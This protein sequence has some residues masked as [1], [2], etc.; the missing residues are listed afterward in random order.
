MN[1]KSDQIYDAFICHATEDKEAVARPLAQALINTGLRIWYDEFSLKL[2]DSLRQSIERGLVQSRFGIV[3]ISPQF[4]E[5]SWPQAELNGL[6][7][8]EMTGDKVII[9]VWFKVEYSD[10]VKRSP[11]MADKVA[12]KIADGMDRVVEQILDVIEMPDKY[13]WKVIEFHDGILTVELSSWKCFSDYV[14]KEISGLYRYIF[15]GQREVS[16]ELQPTLFRAIYNA[17][18]KKYYGLAA[19]SLNFK[20][21]HAMRGRRGSNPKT[22]S[23]NE[24]WA[25]GQQFGLK[26]VLLDWTESPFLASF[27]AFHEQ[28][29]KDRNTDKRIVYAISRFDIRDK[30]DE[31]EKEYLERSTKLMGNSQ[32][33]YKG[34][35]VEFVNPLSDDTARLINQRG[36]FTRVH[37]FVSLEKWVET[38]FRGETNRR[39]MIKIIIPDKKNDRE[40]FLRHLD[41]MNINYISLFPDIYAAALYCNMDIEIAASLGE[42]KKKESV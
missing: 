17:T 22:L 5:K 3:V 14:Q 26:T 24:W 38:H 18:E 30:C 9:P 19:V 13:D 40:L 28:K 41:G 10:I 23:E 15:R 35:I 16:W 6:F 36:V 8:K 1:V 11:I 31:I 20:F 37:D 39:I 34:P 25:L 27:F 2:G 29:Q 21:R 7:A 4:F 42:L 32:F 33:A 12:A